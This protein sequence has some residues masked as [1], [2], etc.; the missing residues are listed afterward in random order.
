MQHVQLERPVSL[1]LWQAV[2]SEMD[3]AAGFHDHAFAFEGPQPPNI[4][5]ELKQI[6]DDFGSEIH[7]R[8]RCQTRYGRGGL[9]R[10]PPQLP[11]HCVQQGHR[12]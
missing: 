8:V 10:H 6:L 5:D 9:V 11:R 2:L 4:T 3:S 1:E 7:G 12:R